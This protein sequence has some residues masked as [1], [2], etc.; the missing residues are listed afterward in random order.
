MKT[1]KTYTFT[2]VDHIGRPHQG[3]IEANGTSNAFNSAMMDTRFKGCKILKTSFRRTDTAKGANR[4]GGLDSNGKQIDART[5]YEKAKEATC[6][7]VKDRFEAAAYK[8]F[9][10]HLDLAIEALYLCHFESNGAVLSMPIKE[11]YEAMKEYDPF[12]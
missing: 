6:K 1:I 3:S 5:A 10:K 4:A 12:K 11:L 8:D 9:L 2:W 7:D